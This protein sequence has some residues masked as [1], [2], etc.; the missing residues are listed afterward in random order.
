[1]K[2][3]VIYPQ[4]ELGGD[5]DAVRR[6]GL[7]AEELGYDHLLA[8]D[9]V[10]GASHD[11]EPKLW[12]PYNETHP[13]HDP[14][15]LFSYLA[16]I[17]TRIEF[18][19]GILILPQRQTVLVAK[20]ATDLDLLSHQRFRMGVGIGWNYVEY[21]ALGQDF[22]TRGRRVDEQIDLL[23]R[24]WVEPLIT[25]NGRFDRIDNACI[26]PRPKRLIPIWIG[27]MSEP[28]YRRGAQLGDGF[29]FDTG[30][31][32]PPDVMSFFKAAKEKVRSVNQ[33]RKEYGR[34]HLPFGMQLQLV[35]AR[36]PTETADL[37]RGWED[38]GGTHAAVQTM[39]RGFKTVEAHVD[40]I[41]EL[42]HHLGF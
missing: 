20:Q 21:D 5:P 8:Y 22:K 18:V 42:K 14:F 13:F 39:H 26:V 31:R 32:G 35:Y 2:I 25:Y 11:R 7:A 9:H 15:M 27:G 34:D 37:V 17:T 12:G 36:S 16:G 23:R 33:Y 10:V 38:L 19:T 3:G 6:F 29:I 4:V 24:L 30:V 1:M 41:A 40:Y 28:A